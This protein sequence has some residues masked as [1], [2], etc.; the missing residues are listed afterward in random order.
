MAMALSK[1]QKRYL[2][3]GVLLVVVLVLKK[4]PLPV[5]VRAMF[6]FSGAM[7]ISLGIMV[8]FNLY[9]GLAARNSAETK[10]SESGVSRGLH[11]FL[12]NAGVLLLVL[13]VPGLTQRFLP[14]WR[15]LAIAGLAVQVAFFLLA[16][17]SRRHLGANWAGE[18]RIAT[19]HELVQSGPYRLIRHP[20]YTALLGMY[21]G[22]ALVSGEMH[23]LLAVVLITL[24]YWRKLRLEET[25]LAGAFG[26]SFAAYQEHSW[27]LVPYVF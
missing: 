11:L 8:L 14:D 3:L 1:Q 27:K 21:V 9:W 15:G 22:M 17:W 10:V 7:R 25:A 19:G 24:A 13:P 12:L 20:I 26:A 18:V 23:A 16:I 4:H 2:Q 5:D 6:R